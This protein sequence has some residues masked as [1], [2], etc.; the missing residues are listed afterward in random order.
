MAITVGVTYNK[1]TLSVKR[2][3]GETKNLSQRKSA[4]GLLFNGMSRRAEK[5][6]SKILLYREHLKVGGET[7]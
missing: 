3:K 5:I 7:T 2:N 4:P 6:T 1:G